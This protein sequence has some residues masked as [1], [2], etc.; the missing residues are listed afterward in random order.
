MATAPRAAFSFSGC[1]AC[2]TFDRF[3]KTVLNSTV[4][5]CDATLAPPARCRGEG[6]AGGMKLTNFAPNTVVDLISTPEFAGMRVSLSGSSAR[7]ISASEPLRSTAETRPTSTPRI[8][9]LAP[10]S[11]T[12]P[13]RGEV[14]V[15]GTVLVKLPRN[16]PKATAAMA[17]RA[18]TRTNAASL[19]RCRTMSSP[20]Q[21]E[22]LK[23]PV[24]P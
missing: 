2:S 23:L 20:P 19:Y 16:I 24:P 8:F 15:T 12:R 14:T 22:R 21:P 7:V 10:G 9:T 6:V 1:T 3:W 5:F 11:I 13:A 4:T 18:R 17:T